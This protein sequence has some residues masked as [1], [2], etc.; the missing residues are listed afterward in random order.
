MPTATQIRK[1]WV[2]KLNDELFSVLAMDHITPGK[3]KAFVQTK[4]RS[5]KNGRLLDHRFRSAD[6]VEKAVLTVVEMNYLYSSDDEHHFMNNQSYEQVALSKDTLGDAL[7]YIVPNTTIK[8]QMHEGTPVGVEVPGSVELKVVDTEPGI[9]GASAQ[10]QT[11]PAT[12]ETGLVVQVPYFIEKDEL[13]RVDTFEGKY[14]E[15]VKS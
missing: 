10:A 14:V 1:G 6:S 12:L 3:G 13:I 5:L 11:K 4:L 8:V 15:R 9:K 7:N 2:I